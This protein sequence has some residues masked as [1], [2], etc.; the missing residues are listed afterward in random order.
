MTNYLYSIQANQELTALQ[1]L[2]N[3][4]ISIDE[5]GLVPT[6]LVPTDFNL[7][8]YLGI[9]ELLQALKPPTPMQ[10]CDEISNV[11][12]LDCV[13]NPYH[14]RFQ[15]GRATY[16]EWS[17]TKKRVSISDELNPKLLVIIG[18]FYEQFI[19]PEVRE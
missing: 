14:K 16:I 9:K 6:T 13:Y 18:R 4:S 2:E 15:I 17:K 8:K 19:P 3:L 12:N 11:M 5:L 1:L 7:K 10:V